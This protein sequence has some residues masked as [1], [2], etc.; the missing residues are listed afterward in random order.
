MRNAPKIPTLIT[1]SVSRLG[2]TTRQ[3]A[4]EFQQMIDRGA[5]VRAAGIARKDP[6]L[7]FR[8][9]LKPKHRIDLFDTRFYLTDI[10][11]RQFDRQIQVEI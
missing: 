6:D 2:I 11:A 7:L 8:H 1:A 4:R 10:L 3:V 5:E 9:R